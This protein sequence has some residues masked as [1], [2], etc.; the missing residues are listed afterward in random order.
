MDRKRSGKYE[1]EVRNMTARFKTS[2]ICLIDAL[3]WKT[4]ETRGKKALR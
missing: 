2:N 4:K 3:E 1:K